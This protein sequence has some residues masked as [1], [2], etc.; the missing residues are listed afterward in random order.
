MLLNFLAKYNKMKVRFF[1]SAILLL[2]L[3]A[4]AQEFKKLDSLFNNL[5]AANKFIGSAAIAKN[6]KIIY[7]KQ[8]GFIDAEN[9]I[10]PDINSKY[11]IGSITKMFTSALILKACEEKKLKLDQSVS[12]FF[13]QLQKGSI[14]T[15]E[16]LL[17]HSSGIHNFTDNENYF[18]WDNA[19]ITQKAL[20]DTIYKGGFDFE[21]GAR[22]EYSNSNYVLLT[23]ILE[24]IYKKSYGEILKSKI[25]VPFSLNN[26]YVGS[27]A[28][29]SKNE[30]FSYS[31]KNNKWE[32]LD[33]TDMS[34]PLGAGCLVSNVGDLVKFSRALFSGEIIKDSS[35]I[36][37][38][39][40]KNNYG[41]GLF[42][43]PFYQKTGFGHSGGID[44]FSTILYYFPKD[45]VT[46]VILSNGGTYS[47]NSVS[48][49]ML[50]E[51]FGREY[52]IPSL[53]ALSF[54]END[55]KKYTGVYSSDDIP[56]KITISN[57]GTELIGQAS[58]QSS[59]P[60][61]PGPTNV[62]SFDEA[63]IKIIFEPVNQTMILQQR[64]KEYKFKMEK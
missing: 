55:L 37:M 53:E 64:G 33:E 27:H 51:M 43:I 3:N 39:T 31:F 16:N 62:Y 24:K 23:L 40:V 4:T 60:L 45:E 59:F 49:A 15:I 10:K 44:N 29:P 25:T 14:I 26:T 19:P 20:L 52:D 32:K 12:E 17:N 8:T 50:S 18:D 1:L 28:N 48:I 35:L 9:K 42:K 22:S 63:G 21:P 46:V 36:K 47:T 57:S 41:L 54:T 6:G 7:A 61:M 2:A 56:L 11:R 58:G 5:E 13:P 30:S 34:I 38:E